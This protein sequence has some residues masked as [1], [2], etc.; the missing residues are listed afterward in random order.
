M[1]NQVNGYL[2]VAVLSFLAQACPSADSQHFGLP[3]ANE[4]QPVF[5]SETIE[6]PLYNARGQIAAVAAESALPGWDGY[7][8]SP[9]SPSAEF[10]AFRL[11]SM[12]VPFCRVSPD[13][14]PEADGNIELV[15]F[16]SKNWRLVVSV[17]EDGVVS[18][19]A[20]CG[21]HSMTGRFARIDE[22]SSDA[23]RGILSSIY[24]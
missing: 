12:L 21:L 18:Y 15:W 4:Q 7:D 8:A 16:R 9:V 22:D 6:E 3:A 17:G 20:K 10:H 24:A 2:N 23:L 13:V 5:V 19:A 11:T 1:T 14:A